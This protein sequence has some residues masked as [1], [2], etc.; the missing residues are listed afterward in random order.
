[1]NIFP[2]INRNVLFRIVTDKFVEIFTT[3]CKKCNE[4]QVEFYNKIVSWYTENDP[5]TWKTIVE[6]TLEDAKKAQ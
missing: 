6:K 1:M 3:K 2:E 4:K 5:D